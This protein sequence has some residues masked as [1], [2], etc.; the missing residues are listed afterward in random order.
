[1]VIIKSEKGGDLDR[2]QWGN[3]GYHS[4]LIRGE[5]KG[6]VLSRTPSSPGKTRRYHQI[7]MGGGRGL[8]QIDFTQG[9]KILRDL[10]SQ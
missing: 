4:L 3:Q 9:N 2:K 8:V 10:R 7:K 6:L 1:M 5:C